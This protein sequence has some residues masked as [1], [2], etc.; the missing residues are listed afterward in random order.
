MGRPS[1]PYTSSYSLGPPLSSALKTLIGINLAIFIIHQIVAP[2]VLGDL[3][4]F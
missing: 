1:S 3:A 4:S 2:Q